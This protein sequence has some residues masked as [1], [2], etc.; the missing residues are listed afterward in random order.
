MF[1]LFQEGL[2]TKLLIFLGHINLQKTWIALWPYLPSEPM[3]VR[4]VEFS[5]I[6]AF[7]Y[8]LLVKIFYFFFN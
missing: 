5:F 4:Y 6:S 8:S 7:M 2:V 3:Y 1:F